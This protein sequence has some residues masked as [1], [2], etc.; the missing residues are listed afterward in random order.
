MLLWCRCACCSGVP[1]VMLLWC[2]WCR[3]ALV[4]LVSCC[5]WCTWCHVASGVPGVMLPLVYLVSCC[6][7]VPG[8]ILPLV[9]LV[10]CCSGVPGVILPLVYLVSCCLWCTWCHVAS[11]VPGVM[12]LWCTWCHLASGVPGVMLLWCTWCHVASGVPGVMLPLVYLVSCCLWLCTCICPMGGGME[13][14]SSHPS[15][16]TALYGW[17]WRLH[18]PIPPHTRPCRMIFPCCLVLSTVFGGMALFAAAVCYLLV[19]SVSHGSLP[20]ML[21]CYLPT[22]QTFPNLCDTCTNICMSNVVIHVCLAKYTHTHTH[23]HTT[24][25]HMHTHTHIH[26]HTHTH[27]PHT[28]TTYTCRICH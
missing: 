1:G 24:Y 12:L 11:G 4:Y 9:Y 14:S 6:S 19:C 28:H 13:T 5:L 10:S 26:T 17:A 23:T 21:P 27:T 7:G 18:P 3:V 15:T 20:P 22:N 16:H 2:T 8:V 25:T